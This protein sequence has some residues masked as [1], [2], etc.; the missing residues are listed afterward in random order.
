MSYDIH[1]HDSCFIQNELLNIRNVIQVTKN[2]LSAL[3]AKF[4][5][6]RDPP[7]LFISEQQELSYK[8]QELRQ[9]ELQLSQQ[10]SETKKTEKSAAKF[11]R[12]HLPNKQRTSIQVKPGTN[13]RTALYKA[14]RLRNLEPEMCVIHAMDGT[15]EVIHWDEDVSALKV[16]EIRVDIIDRFPIP[17]SIS[18]NFIRKTFFS[19]AFCECC[20]RLLFQGF[21]CRTCGYRFHPR[22]ATGV[23][24]VCKQIRCPD[25]YYQRLLSQNYE[26]SQAGI[27]LVPSITVNMTQRHRHHRLIHNE[28]SSS[29][30]NVCFNAVNLNGHDPAAAAAAMDECSTFQPAGV[31]APYSSRFPHSQSAQASPTNAVRPRPR[32]RST[33]ENANSSIRKGHKEAAPQ[34]SIE[35]WEIR[36]NQV[37]IQCRIGSGSFGTVYKAQWHGPVAIK[38]L[39]VTD[40]TP[41]QLQAFKNEVAVLR[42]TRHANILLFMGVIRKPNLAIVTQWCEGSSLYRCL[43]VHE[44]RFDVQHII[45][46]TRQT[47]QGMDYLHAK[48]IIHRDLKSNNIFFNDMVVKIGDFGLATVKTRWSGGQQYHQPSGSILW[49]APEV[50]RMKDENP[51]SFQSDVYAFGIVLY[52]VLSGQLPYTNINCKDQILFMVGRGYLKPDVSKIPP[53]TPKVLQRM[54]EDCI[55]YNR[56]ERPQFRHILSSVESLLFSLP[57]LHRSTSEPIL[58]RTHFYSDNIFYPCSSPKSPGNLQLY[59]EFNFCPTTGMI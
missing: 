35:D 39:N 18:H 14:L 46:I 36:S 49:M 26:N 50:I 47:A 55:K 20:R 37:E 32:A 40:P 28:R 53:E 16:E 1:I 15:E 7:S 23:P 24:V 44:K 38:T 57:K 33:D 17:T 21:Y 58:N 9:K 43:H 56:D 48:N 42:K 54:M 51:Y 31:S 27:L 22:C 10:L 34:E 6:L 4:S 59:E 19:L 8:L 13:L 29:T 41:A 30:P 25:T 5:D 3:K 12:A 52:E 2:N 45:E 11:V